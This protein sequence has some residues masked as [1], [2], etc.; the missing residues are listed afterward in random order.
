MTNDDDQNAIDRL[1]ARSSTYSRT[2]TGAA[3][4]SIACTTSFIRAASSMKSCA[5]V[6]TVDDLARFI[7][8]RRTLLDGG[9]LVDFSEREIDA[10]RHLRPRRA[11]GSLYEKSGV[12]RG[13]PFHT[14][15]MKSI[16]L[17]KT[18]AGWRITAVLW[19]DEHD[20]APCPE[21]ID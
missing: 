21:R 8:P 20:G 4:I 18:P 19:D 11:T 1:V 14:K 2:R 13:T 15:G 3:G 17:V 16:Q 5:D 9:D 6:P 7:A 10:H 12:L